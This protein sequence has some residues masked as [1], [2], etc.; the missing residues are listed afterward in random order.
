MK[1]KR[2]I[3]LAL[4]LIMM[5]GMVGCNNTSNPKESG[6]SQPSANRALRLSLTT[7]LSSLDWEQTTLVSDMWVWHQMFEGLYGMDEANNGYYQELAQDVDIS[8]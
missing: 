7:A 4:T 5:L 8:D 2:L 6:G 3:A 1:T